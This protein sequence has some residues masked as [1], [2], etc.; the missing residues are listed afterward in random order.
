M[1]GTREIERP[2]LENR[3]Y[4]GQVDGEG[5]HTGNKGYECVLA[6]VLM[7]NLNVAYAAAI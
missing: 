3:E 1:Q 7:D 6:S 4:S 2:P 5:R